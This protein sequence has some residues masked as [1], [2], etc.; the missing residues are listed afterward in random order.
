M[1][2]FHIMSRA[3][4]IDVQEVVD[5]QGLGGGAIFLPLF[6]SFYE[7]DSIFSRSDLLY[8]PWYAN[9]GLARR[10]SEGAE[11]GIRWSSHRSRHSLAGLVISTAASERSCSGKTATLAQAHL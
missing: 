1:P 8:L 3:A 10:N 11:P 4:L 6:L 5:Q 2:E 7:R 9:G